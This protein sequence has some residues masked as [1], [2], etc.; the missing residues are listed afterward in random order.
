MLQDK[1]GRRFQ[2]LR[3]SITDVCNYRCDYCLPDGYQGGKPEG[4]LSLPE[5]ETLVDAFVG[6]GTEK[7]RITGGEPSLRKD[8]TDIISLIRKNP[9]VKHI[10]MTTNGYSLEKHVQ[11]WA[12]A[13]LDSLNISI[14]SLDPRLFTAITGHD[15]LAQILA[16][17]EKAIALGIKV[18]VNAVLMRQ[19]NAEALDSFLDWIKNKPITLRFIELMQTGDNKTLFDA[20]HV[21]GE[22]I[23]ANILSRGWVQML[24]SDTAGPAQEFSHPEYRGKLGLIMPYSK[25]FCVSC[26]RLRVTAKGDLHLCLFAEKGLSLRDELQTANVQRVQQKLVSLL[27]DKHATHYLDE[28]YTGATQHLAMLGG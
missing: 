25:D 6:L 20:Q 14:D 5:I 10:A 21:S 7:V 24:R 8:L 3:L 2:Y 12:E 22:P 23:K 17:I 26:N 11:Q 15:H 1:F 28:G 4:F 16:G 18:K 9:G 19:I 27:G 13:G